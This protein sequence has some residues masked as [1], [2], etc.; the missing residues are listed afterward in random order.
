MTTVFKGRVFSVEAG[1]VPFPDGRVHR[2]EVVRHAPSVVLIPMPD[3]EHV[4]L[5]RQFR[6]AVNQWLWE[7]PA[8]GVDAGEEPEAAARRECHEEVGLV[9]RTLVR[10][11]SFFPTPGYCDEEMIV[12]KLTGLEAPA[13]IAEHD[14]DE[15]IEVRTFSLG[16]AREM[17]QSGEIVDMKTLAGLRLI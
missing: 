2:I 10:L 9:P 13:A 15:V 12:F 5:V 7:L 11:G 3:P 16:E 6:F 8:G 14:E 1:D 4:I 17:L